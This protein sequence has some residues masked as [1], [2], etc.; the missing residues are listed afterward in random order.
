[1]TL[2]PRSAAALFA[3][4]KLTQAR[5]MLA[6][7]R[8]ELAHRAGVSAASISHYESGA[9]R[10]RPA[11][12]AQLA[13]V[14]QVPIEFLTESRM[15][16]PLPSVDTSFFRSLRRTTQRDRERASAHAGLLA[17]LVSELERHVTLPAFEPMPDQALDPEDVPQKAEAIATVVRDRWGLG[18]G[19]IKHVVRLVE[20]HGVVVARLPFESSDVDAFSWVGGTHPLVLLGDE[21]RNFER[22]RF[23]ACHELAHVLIHAAD[24]EPAN[25]GM[26]LQAH[27]FA[28]ALLMPAAAVIDA[29]PTGRWDWAQLIRTKEHWGI[30]IAAQLIRGRD[31]GLI[32][33]A[34]YQS[35]MKYMSQMGWRRREPGP[36]R[37]PEDPD[38]INQ[39]IG[40]LEQ[41]GTGL[42]V[43]ADDANLLPRDV[44]I[45]RL[46]LTPRTP[47]R[48]EAR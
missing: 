23:D 3:P 18:D 32:T 41:S 14:L 46:S 31:L 11:T 13:L 40:L 43:L 5:Q 33:P 21:K 1:V 35:K 26:E 20:R 17:Q 28:G 6:I 7:T 42:D 16:V 37:R 24:P 19:P 22:S 47:L 29:W 27:R 48:I 25:P 4:Y 12:L 34:T 30:S 45:Q 38:L 36:A 2:D 44:L 39:A 15:P 10:P 8:V 9:I